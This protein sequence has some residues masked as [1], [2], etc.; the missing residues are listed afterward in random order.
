MSGTCLCMGHRLEP[1]ARPT[2]QHSRMHRRAAWHA[3]RLLNE[4]AGS[5]SIPTLRLSTRVPTSYASDPEHVQVRPFYMHKHG[6]MYADLDMEALRD[7]SPLLKGQTEPVFAALMDDPPHSFRHNVPNAWMASPAGHPFW[8]VSTSTRSPLLQN[9][10]NVLRC[11]CESVETRR[12]LPAFR[13][14]L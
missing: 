10:Q 6:G 8:Q 3:W 13:L 2:D 5:R 9:A 12:G 7:L 1:R 4:E 14:L 11:S